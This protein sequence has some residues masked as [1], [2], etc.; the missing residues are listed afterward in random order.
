[1]YNLYADCYH[2]KEN[3]VAK[4]S[5]FHPLNM[6][7]PMTD[8]RKESIKVC[9]LIILSYPLDPVVPTPWAV[10]VNRAKGSIINYLEGA[11]E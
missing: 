3:P 7:F 11:E 1:M 6:Y 10:I 5:K 4:Q 8:K 9:N 2:G